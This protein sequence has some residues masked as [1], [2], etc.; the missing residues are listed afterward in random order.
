MREMTHRDHA[1]RNN[2][3]T[4]VVLWGIV[5]L[6]FCGIIAKYLFLTQ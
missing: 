6:F 3:V 2:R 4:A 5:A 1:V